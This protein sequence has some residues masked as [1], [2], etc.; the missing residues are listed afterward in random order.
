MYGVG[1]IEMLIGLGILSNKPRLASYAASAWLLSIAGNLALNGDY[2]IAVPDVNMA[3]A[4]YALARSEGR[5]RQSEEREY[6][7]E[8]P[9]LEAEKPGASPPRLMNFRRLG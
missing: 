7:A 5:R 8:D 3:I 4:A 6:F 2:D 1:V 9:A